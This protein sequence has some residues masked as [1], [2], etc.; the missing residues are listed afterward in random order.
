MDRGSNVEY[1]NTMNL[2]TFIKQFLPGSLLLFQTSE[3]S[4]SY[5]I[6]VE[7]SETIQLEDLDACFHLIDTTS[8]IHYANSCMGWHPKAKRKE[9]IL[10]DLKYLIVR[11]HVESEVLGFASFMLTFEDGI[12]VIYLYEI[13]LSEAIRGIGIGKH[14]IQILRHVG[15]RSCMEKIMLT[16]FEVNSEARKFYER[17]GFAL[18]EISPAPRKLRRGVVKQPHYAILSKTLKTNSSKK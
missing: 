2:P 8:K 3:A 17:L 11:Q 18:D 4:G 12:E 1:L 14:L 5:R 10:P 9:M 7:S 13:H 6:D 15:Q 16:I